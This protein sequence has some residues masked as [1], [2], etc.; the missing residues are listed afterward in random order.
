MINSIVISRES[1][2]SLVE[3]LISMALG[4]ML[5]TAVGSLFIGSSRSDAELQKA[6]QQIES[7]RYA[8]EVLT[9]DLKHTGFYGEY[10]SLP[11]LAGPYDPCETFSAANLLAGLALPVQVFRAPNLTTRADISATTCDDIGLLANSNL[12]TGSDV[13]VIRRADTSALAIG[14]VAALNEAYLQANTFQ[15][16]IQFGNGAAITAPGKADGTA[17][18]I[19]KKDGTTAAPIRKFHVHVYFVAPCSTGSNANGTCAAGDDTIPTLKRLE[20][21]V[22]AANNRDMYIVP[23][24]SGIEY[25]KAEWGIDEQPATVN[26]MTGVAG[27]GI[28]ESYVAAPTAAQLAN[29]VSVKLNLLARN[30][31]RSSGHVDDK[32]YSLGTG[33]TLAATN[34]AFKRHVFSTDVLMINVAGRKEIPE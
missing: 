21:T 24:A 5:M 18:A 13:I 10:S 26:E 6:G 9:N 17:A 23:I 31:E 19:F 7:G 2:L 25:L 20:L 34:D 15:A 22:D 28:P 30:T 8:I 11:A 14:D 33:A 32:T 27:N 1:G 3:L 12:A 4:L 16:E 29:A